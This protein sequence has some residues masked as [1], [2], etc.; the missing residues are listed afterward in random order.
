MCV[1]GLCH[2]M[3]MPEKGE[4]V[5]YAPQLVPSC[6][7][8]FDGLKRAYA[9]R[10]EAEDS[11]EDSENEEGVDS[12]LLES[13]EDEIDDDGEQY[14]E[15]LQVSE[16]KYHCF[17]SGYGVFPDSESGSKGLKKVNNC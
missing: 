5:A 11:E 1:L 10:T 12:E 17:G 13:D 4:V 3:Q 2:L 14:L 8:L 9:A 16:Y 7:L 15:S 6:L